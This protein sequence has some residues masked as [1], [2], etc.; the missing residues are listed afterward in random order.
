MKESG[1]V[2]LVKG[3]INSINR[4]YNNFVEV[5]NKFEKDLDGIARN[6]LEALYIDLTNKKMHS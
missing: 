3:Y 5:Y 1:I 4:A 2:K 6:I